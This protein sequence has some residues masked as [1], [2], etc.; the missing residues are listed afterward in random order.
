MADDFTS[1][2]CCQRGLC[3]RHAA[4]ITQKLWY[5]NRTRKEGPQAALDECHLIAAHPHVPDNTTRGLESLKIYC[6]YRLQRYDEAAAGC[7]L[8]EHLVT[9][10]MR[11]DHSAAEI[12]HQYLAWIRPMISGCCCWWWQWWWQ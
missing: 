1:F 4:W 2:T 3:M 6:L 10:E 12:F 7:D 5:I 11:L 8:L 9:V